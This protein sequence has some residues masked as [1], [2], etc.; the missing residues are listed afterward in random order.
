MYM[1]L[2]I[3]IYIDNQLK[4]HQQWFLL[5]HTPPMFRSTMRLSH[6]DIW[7][8]CKNNFSWPLLEPIH[9]LF[10]DTKVLSP[11]IWGI[12][13]HVQQSVLTENDTERHKISNKT[14]NCFIHRTLSLHLFTFAI[15]AVVKVFVINYLPIHLCM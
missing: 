8:T 3:H 2:Y 7:M 13:K 5:E 14:L 10:E 12:L 1:Y 9:L 15:L 6:S 11:I 4:P